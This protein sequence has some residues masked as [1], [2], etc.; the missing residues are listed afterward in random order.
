MRN[1]LRIGLFDAPF[2]LTF[3]QNQPHHILLF[4]GGILSIGLLTNCGDGSCAEELVVED[5]GKNHITVRWRHDC[6]TCDTWELCHK[7]AGILNGWV[8]VPYASP[9]AVRGE[10]YTVTGL[11]SGTTYL[12]T[13]KNVMGQG[14]RLKTVGTVEQKTR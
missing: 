11:A 6:Y 10:S 2:N 8:C 13:V 1:W 4:F 12:I 9:G 7:K 14:C 5:V 3:F